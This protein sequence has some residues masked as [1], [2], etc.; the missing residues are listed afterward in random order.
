MNGRASSSL[1]VDM[2][3]RE[4]DGIRFSEELIKNCAGAMY[5][6]TYLSTLSMPCLSDVAAVDTVRV[7]FVRETAMSLTVVRQPHLLWHLLLG[8]CETLR[9]TTGHGRRLTV[10]SEQVGSPS[11]VTEPACLT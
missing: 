3:D 6:G 10:S 8:C 5:L 4:D 2:L 9:F 11:T 7:I 1:V